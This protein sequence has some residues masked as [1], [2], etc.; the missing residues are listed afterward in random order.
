MRVLF[1][2]V[3][4]YGHIFPLL[5]LAQA[6]RD[7]GDEVALATAATFAPLVEGAGL[8]L[9]PTGLAE[10]ELNARYAPYRAEMMKLPIPERRPFVYAHRFARLDAPA[11]V[12]ELREHVLAFRP[13]LIVHE[14]A[15]LASPVVAAQLGL[16]TALHSF[17]RM[18]SWASIAAAAIE[19]APMW[20]RAGVEPEPNAGL[21]RGPFV[22]IAPPSLGA[23]QPPAGTAVLPRRPAD[24][25]VSDH[26]DGLPLIYATLGTVVTST[27]TLDIL[28][29]G[30]AEL[31]AD[32]LLTT[33]W[34]N[35][36]AEL[37]SIPANATV[38]RFV[39]QDEVLPRCSL[40][41]THAGSG[42]MLGA[43]AHGVP[44]LAVPYFADQFEN[45][46]AAAAAGAARVVMPDELSGDAVRDAARALLEDPSYRDAA[47]AIAAEIAAMPSAAE[48]AEQLAA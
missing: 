24:G 27:E 10:A 5:P 9:L 6:C 44:L 38:E 19:V 18:V 25:V 2:S 46:D 15:D 4:G 33:G 41:V 40:M 12:D 39:P 29:A 20:E 17:G 16:P 13:D 43:L 22:D 21:F 3:A 8:Q 30:L 35:D 48:V 32:V 14:M 23:D 11:R 1:S 7:R 45:A 37:S 28:L 42:S 31:D 34:Q 36:P 47:R 26:A